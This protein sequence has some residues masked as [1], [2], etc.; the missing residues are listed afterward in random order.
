MANKLKREDIEDINTF[1]EPFD[2]NLYKTADNAF[3][4]PINF[5]TKQVGEMLQEYA[6]GNPED[7]LYTANLIESF[8]T[9]KHPEYGHDKID[10][11]I[12][13]YEENLTNQVYASYGQHGTRQYKEDNE[14]EISRVNLLGQFA[15]F[16][17]DLNPNV[18]ERDTS[19]ISNFIGSGRR[20]YGG[21][22]DILKTLYHETM[23]DFDLHPEDSEGHEYKEDAKLYDELA[24]NIVSKGQGQDV[25][26]TETAGWMQSFLEALFPKQKFRGHR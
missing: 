5:G 10:K 19:F 2:R 15:P 8:L 26:H 9:K 12:K 18:A 3:L 14:G 13:D 24:S 23:H 7:S 1:D 17:Q 6:V 21:F 16:R 25:P 20:G 11:I 4:G 22:H